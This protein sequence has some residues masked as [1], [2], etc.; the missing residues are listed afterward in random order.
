MKDSVALKLPTESEDPEVPKQRGLT[1]SQKLETVRLFAAKENYA[2]LKTI[3]DALAA[4]VCACLYCMNYDVF[5][6]Y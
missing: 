6:N 5:K 1:Y 2:R 4:K 3:A